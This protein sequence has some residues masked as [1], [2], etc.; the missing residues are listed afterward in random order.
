M[1]KPDD[2]TL[3][4]NRKIARRD[5][6][7]GVFNTTAALSIGATTPLSVLAASGQAAS[8]SVDPSPVLVAPMGGEYPPL[9]TGMRGSGY[10]SA[11]ETGHAMRDRSLVIDEAAVVDV[12]E[13]YDLLVVGGGI[14]GLSAAYYYRKMQ[15]RDSRIL[16]MD[17]HDDFG[18]HAKRNE[19]EY[20]GRTLISNA[21]TFDLATDG[22]EIV[23]RLLEEIG[24]PDMRELNRTTVDPYFYGRHGM[25]Q[26]VWFDKD[27]FGEDKLIPD[28]GAWTEY[29][30]LYEP[31]VP[32]DTP[33]RWETFFREAPLPERAKHD[34][35]RIY[36]EAVE[37]FPD[38]TPADRER[39]LRRMTYE[40]FLRDVAKVDPMA[41]AYQRDRTFGSA[42]GMSGM[43]AWAARRRGM[44]GFLG[45]DAGPGNPVP[46]PQSSV[47]GAPRKYTD[48]YHFPDGNATVARLLVRKLLPDAVPGS[49]LEDS[50]GARV[51]YDLLDRSGQ[52]SRIRLNSTVVRVTTTS[53]G[54]EVIYRRDGKFY[55][56][57]GKHAIL[58]CWHSVIPYICPEL[59]AWQKEALSYSVKAPNLWV[60]V[61]LR[62]WEAFKKAGACLINAPNGYYTQ[63][64]LEHP[65]KIGS[66][67]HASSPDQ[68]TKLTM[69]RGYETPGLPTKEQYRVGRAKLYATDF[70]TFE[71]HARDQLGRMLGPHGFDPAED[72]VGLTV[73]RWGHGY[74]Y[75][76][77]D[78]F[79][80]FLERGE[81]PPH[82]RAR[83]P[84][85]NIAIANTDAA[86]VGSTSCA[87]DQAHRAVSEILAYRLPGVF[88]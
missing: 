52:S 16:V 47:P 88:Y 13:D 32:Y 84:C 63:M 56:V 70:A 50:I 45:I 4:M 68:P 86:G 2:D 18:G 73:N 67:Q 72:I 64:I 51:R 62:N 85:G 3:G 11:Y 42:R 74:C 41:M 57:R 39:A 83:Q 19:F 15:G 5:F 10:S 58:A 59:P 38:L 23:A 21:G 7:N 33:Q 29:K 31:N 27:T 69:L 26:S 35:K 28:P 53:N 61:W 81:Q 6:I 75:M 20:G 78:V 30:P 17:N 12:G 36:T 82:E 9:K 44:P 14:S 1:N 34:V 43:S 8:R 54:V 87:I 66:Y 65:M 46:R 40:T 79:D 48:K 76:Y 25:G 55:R 71:Y 24:V 80:E 37:Y 22:S 60:N 49:S 77:S